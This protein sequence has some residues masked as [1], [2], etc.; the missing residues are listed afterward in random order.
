MGVPASTAN[1]SASPPAGAEAPQPS[2]PDLELRRLT[3]G[4]KD[5]LLFADALGERGVE[6]LYL[7]ELLA[8]T[9]ATGAARE[10]VGRRQQRARRRSRRGHGL[11][12]QRRHQ[13]PPAPSGAC[14]TCVP[15]RSARR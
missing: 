4:N 15:T 6:V 7:Q 12:A 3:P 5:E 13:H 1:A 14:A 11:R 9:L 2:R 10:A 8:E